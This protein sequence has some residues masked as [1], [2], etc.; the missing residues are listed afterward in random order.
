MNLDHLLEEIRKPHAK[1]GGGAVVIFIANMAVNLSLMMDKKNWGELENQAN[2]SY[3]TMIKISDKLKK[4]ADDDI[5]YTNLMLDEFKK[6]SKVD[7][8]F[9]LDAAKPQIQM[10]ELC[11][12]AM[13]TLSFYLEHGKKSTI[14]DG[15]IANELLRAAVFSSLPTIKINLGKEE[16]E[17]LVGKT[18]EEIINLYEKN[19]KII[20]RRTL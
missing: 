10:N 16:T 9:F 19:K 6:T 13:K 4:L 1:P 7:H 14:S 20:E 17:K 5:Y 11:L 2:V 8:K 18:L 3:E 12:E 15:E